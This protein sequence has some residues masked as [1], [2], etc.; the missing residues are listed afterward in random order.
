[1]IAEP[2]CRIAL[3]LLSRWLLADPSPLT[4]IASAPAAHAYTFK[5]PSQAGVYLARIKADHRIAS[6]KIVVP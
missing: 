5:A 6:R 3:V 2:A 1:M 4:E